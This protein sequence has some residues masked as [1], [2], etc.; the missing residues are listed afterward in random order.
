MQFLSS[1]PSVIKLKFLMKYDVIYFM[2]ENIFITFTI[3]SMSITPKINTNCLWNAEVLINE[4][5]QSREKEMKNLIIY[6]FHSINLLV[7]LECCR[8]V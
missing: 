2:L 7:A 6:Q 8:F 1:E 5:F 4:I 3:K